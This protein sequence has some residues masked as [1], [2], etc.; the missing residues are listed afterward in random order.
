MPGF[1][2]FII[3]NIN[4]CTLQLYIKDKALTP[5]LVYTRMI[6]KFKGKYRD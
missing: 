6:K 1:A 2:N 4:L 5:A 3:E